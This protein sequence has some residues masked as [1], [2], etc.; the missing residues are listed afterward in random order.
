[1]VS[2]IRDL[3]AAKKIISF[4][5]ISR[6]STGYHNSAVDF[7]ARRVRKGDEGHRHFA[8]AKRL[9]LN[10]RRRKGYAENFPCIEERFIDGVRLHQKEIQFWVQAVIKLIEDDVGGDNVQIGDDILKVKF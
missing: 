7:I 6:R 2:T 3:K 8:S 9:Q 5:P 1:M 4:D 10:R